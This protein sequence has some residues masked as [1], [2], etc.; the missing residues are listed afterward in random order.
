MSKIFIDD[1]LNFSETESLN[2][3]VKFNQSDGN[4]NPIDLYLSDSEI[5]NSQWLFW[6]T[7]QRYF[8]VGQIAICLLKLSYDRWL[9][10][11]IK[12]VTKELNVCGGIN[13][14]GEECAQYRQ[15][16]G[17]VIIK[18]HKTHQTQG[19]FYNTVSNDLEVLEILPSKYDGDEFV[20]YDKVSLT[21]LQLLRIIEHQKKSWI[22]ALENQ[23]GVYLITD[24]SNG[25]LYVG[26]ATSDS[27]MLLA[28]WSDYIAN[29]HGGDVRL[30]EIVST[31]GIEYIK[32]NFVYSIL[33]N[34]NARV[35]DH[36]I[37]QRETWW[38]KIL[39]SRKFGYN[40]N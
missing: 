33:E 12:K 35:D 39:Q 38:K 19:M 14:E 28:R 24:K 31:K 7:K 40:G 30:R 23:K 16:F 11:T 25:K 13:Y 5:I 26:S 32:A 18:Y 36:V 6:R 10:T 1:L 29:G 22:E 21:Y 17:R 34:F 15:Y 4:E 8:T 9:L 3:K 27:G 37:L 20:G 2:V